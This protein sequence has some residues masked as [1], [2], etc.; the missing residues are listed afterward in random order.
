MIRSVLN[1]VTRNRKPIRSKT[2]TTSSNL[3]L[4]V[5]AVIIGGGVVGC[6][7]LY[8][9]SKRGVR[10]LLAERGK[11]TCGTTFHTAGLVWSLRHSQ[12]EIEMLKGTKRVFSE[13]GEENCGWINNGSIFIA[14]SKEE[15][16][17][18]AVLSKLGKSLGVNSFILS[19]SEAAD[20][21]PLLESKQFIGALYSPDDGVVDPYLLCNTL[22]KASKHLNGTVLENC[23]VKEILFDRNEQGRNVRG[24]ITDK[25]I[26]EADCVINARGLW[27]NQHI[28]NKCTSLPF[29]TMKHS[30][31]VTDTIQNLNK[32]PNIRDH[33]LSIY[34]RVQGQS[35][36]IGGYESNPTVVNNVPNDFQFSLYEMDW[37]TFEPLMQNAIKLCPSLESVGIKS[38]I[39]GPEAFSIDRRP[40]VGP[41]YHVN[42]LFHACA[43]SSNGMML[44]GGVSERVA[45]WV[46]NGMSSLGLYDL[47]RFDSKKVMDKAWI[48][49]K[50]VENY[51]NKSRSKQ[52]VPKM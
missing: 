33:D 44:S 35:L 52:T 25:G 41:D 50:C 10:V 8:Q 9:L 2:V 4:Q 38:S 21:F 42:G 11:L 19:E 51:S 7:I 48:Q 32:W 45:D 1:S 28:L 47:K 15:L 6:C 16:R 31:V 12:F 26:V 40:I 3:P 49:Q 13:L 27:S 46:V 37:T 29:I 18:F 23:N 5:D 39:C 30:Y 14:H 17:E 22:I 36:I 43:F 34:F 24:V 20:M